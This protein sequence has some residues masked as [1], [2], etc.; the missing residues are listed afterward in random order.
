M[1]VIMTTPTELEALIENSVNK[2]LNFQK[3]EPKEEQDQ[4][5]IID[6]AATFARLS[7]ATLYSLVSRREIPFCK[8]S[9]RL[10]FSKQELTNWIKAGRNKTNAEISADADT[11]IKSKKK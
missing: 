10:Y 1:Q 7:K 8:K 9:K 6:E 3:S 4:L 5:F 2:A 11:Y